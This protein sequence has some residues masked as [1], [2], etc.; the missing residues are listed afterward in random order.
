MTHRVLAGTRQASH[1]RRREEGK[2]GK[3][4]EVGCFA[5]AQARQEKREKQASVRAPSELHK[6]AALTVV[7]CCY[8]AGGNK[9]I[10]FE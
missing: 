2:K 3:R 4:G 10:L 6:G 1:R 8:F 9:S 5:S 7:I